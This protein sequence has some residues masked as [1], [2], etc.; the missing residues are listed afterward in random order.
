MF[1]VL[2]HESKIIQVLFFLLDVMNTFPGLKNSVKV[3]QVSDNVL[4]K[5]EKGSSV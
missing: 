2:L 1:Q 5:L 3:L 4:A